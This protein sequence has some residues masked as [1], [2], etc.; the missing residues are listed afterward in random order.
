MAHA[1]KDLAIGECVM[2]EKVDAQRLVDYGSA[3]YVVEELQ[4]VVFH[5]NG[6]A[7]PGLD[8]SEEMMKI[9]EG[10]LEQKEEKQAY[11]T[12]EEKQRGR[13]AVKK[14]KTKTK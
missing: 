8:I 13:P 12:K 4:P 14:R 11:Q 6:I 9:Q 3:E 10:S 1:G 5:S 2:L 7:A